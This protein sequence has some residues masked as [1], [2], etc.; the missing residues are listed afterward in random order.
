MTHYVLQGTHAA[1]LSARHRK[2]DP[3][4]WIDDRS[5]GQSP[6]GAAWESLWEY[7]AQYE[8]PRWREWHAQAQQAGHG[9]G[10]FFIL[11]DFVDAIRNG[12]RPPIDV[13]DAATWSAIMPLSIESVARGNAPVEVPD[14]TKGRQG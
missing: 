9:G 10:D 12:T 7:S 4:I 13:Y 11:K 5:P 8:H 1:Y 14:F 6:G 2:E 3:L